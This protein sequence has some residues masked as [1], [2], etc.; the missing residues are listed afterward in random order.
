MFPK[1]YRISGITILNTIFRDYKPQ[2]QKKK[3]AG[4]N[5]S[6]CAL[7]SFCRSPDRDCVAGTGRTPNNC[8]FSF[9]L[10]GSSF[11]RISLIVLLIS[12]AFLP[13]IERMFVSFL[14]FHGLKP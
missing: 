8:Y 1:D 9:I 11:L 6:P 13:S 12:N 4:K 14:L 5:R 10:V 3:A 7:H 2:K